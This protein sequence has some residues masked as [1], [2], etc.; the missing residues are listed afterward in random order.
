[1]ALQDVLPRTWSEADGA[2]SLGGVALSAI[3]ERFG[4]PAYVFDVAHVEERF[5]EY[6]TALDGVGTPVYATKAFL[7]TAFAELLAESGWWA[8]V[9]S[10]GEAENVRRGGVGAE[11]ILLHGNLKTDEELELAVRGNVAI[12]VIDSLGELDRL[13]SLASTSDV[14]VDVM[15]RLN[16]DLHL[17]THP[18]VLTS[19]E[20]A[21]FGLVPAE[22]TEAVRRI[23]A[24]RAVRMRGVHLHVGSQATDPSLYG[25]I[26]D[27]LVDFVSRHRDGFP[28]SPILL[29]AGGGMAAPYLRNDPIVDPMLVADAMRDALVRSDASGRIGTT[30]LLLEPGRALVAN[31]AVLLY[32]VGVRKPLPSGG[33]IIAL[34]GGMADNPRPALY[35][36]QYELLAVDRLDEQAD[37]P[38]RVVGRLCESDVMLDRALLP[39]AIEPGDVVAMP[40][41]GAYTFSMSS[42]YNGLRRPPVLFVKDG[43]V[44]EVVRRETIE[45]MLAGEARLDAA[46]TWTY[47]PGRSNHDHERR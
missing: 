14:V 38:F 36:S 1:M 8:D 19:G 17:A 10:L 28:I 31:A 25:V 5:A 9:V 33:E 7:C 30:H 13:I 18:K 16:E 24:S 34:D 42:R 3:A 4:T 40:A 37:G 23:A 47:N 20:E 22:A 44:H 27:R 2:A 46:S 39:D 45:D 29:D 11:R 41:A 21:K 12:I 35:G 32:T 26:V 6:S 15:I 43:V